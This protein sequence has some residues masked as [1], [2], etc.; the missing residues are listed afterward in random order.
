MA[1]IF[2][3]YVREDLERAR[4]LVEALEAR[5]WSVFWDEHLIPGPG[6][7][8][9]IQ[10]ELD[11]ARCV[12]VLWS[13]QSVESKWVLD[14]A[15][16]GLERDTLISVLI[17][18]VKLPLGFRQG[19]V[20]DLVDWNGAEDHRE[21][22]RLTKGVAGYV[23]PPTPV[24]RPVTADLVDGQS[25]AE[26]Q[27]ESQRVKAESRIRKR[28]STSPPTP[29]PV[30]APLLPQTGSEGD[31]PSGHHG[32]EH[33]KAHQWEQ[34]RS[35]ESPETGRQLP[36]AQTPAEQRHSAE[37]LELQQRAP[38]RVERAA[39]RPPKGEPLSGSGGVRFETMAWRPWW[40]A[41]AAALFVM[42]VALSAWYSSRGGIATETE[43][44]SFGFP[45]VEQA[46]GDFPMCET[47][48]AVWAGGEQLLI[49]DNEVREALFAFPLSDGRLDPS[50]STEL[51]LGNDVE[52]SDIEALASLKS[53][54]V[55][56]FGSHSRNTRCDGRSNRRRFLR[57][58]VTADGFVA[59]S[60]G[61][62]QMPGVISCGS[63]FG[64]IFDDKP[65]LAEVCRRIDAVEQAADE[66]WQSDATP[67][68]QVGACNEAQPFNA[69]GAM[70]VADASGEAVWIGLRSPLLPVASWSGDDYMAIMLRMKDLD[71]YAFDAAALVDLDGFGIR[72]L[73]VNNGHIFGLGL[74]NNQHLHIG[75][76]PYEIVPFAVEGVRR[77]IDGYI[78]VSQLMKCPDEACFIAVSAY[79]TGYATG[80]ESV[81]EPTVR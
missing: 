31:S 81:Q 7:R 67:E 6:Y 20:A 43:P 75:V 71:E 24:A 64:D 54:E 62:V 15:E 74:V 35:E 14:E 21:L 1:D 3:S 76:W 19:H 63:L 38:S 22:E 40:A 51:A 11:D 68:V 44:V 77:Q 32:V 16:E 42:A 12:V 58:S 49:G 41:V 69:E 17:E 26:P 47:S 10:R 39:A 73:T 9:T 27:P 2:L 66:I 80:S 28:P 46:L 78:R 25:E 5:G 56:V 72:E 65:L 53:G 61:V 57:G 37:D 60:D 4:P 8:R 30:A 45:D 36:S 79:L 13:R 70:A 48:S 50:Q 34:I 18:R 23:P 29:K 59:S 55:V 52:I 33:E